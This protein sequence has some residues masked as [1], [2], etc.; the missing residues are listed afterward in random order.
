MKKLVC[1]AAL[2]LSTAS[3]FAQLYVRGNIGYNLPGGSQVIGTNYDQYYVGQ[4][5]VNESTTERVYGSFGSG[6]SFHVGV[7]ASI[8]GMLGY[9]V[10]VG[11]VVGKKY[12]EKQTYADNFG[13]D[14]YH[15][16]TWAGSIQIAPSL[17]FTAGTGNIQP[18]TRV[19]PVLGFTKMKREYSESDSYNDVEFKYEYELTG[20]VSIGFKGVLGVNFNAGKKIQFFSEISFV[21]MSTA[22][23]EIEITALTVNGEDALNS[24]PKEERKTKLKDKIDSDDQSNVDLREKYSMGSIGLQV[25]VKYVLK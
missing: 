12:S 15:T 18:Y 22:P 21:S 20:G 17:T 9:D 11:Y 8:N 4:T 1:L 2:V 7:G 6:L 14:R 19:G 23:K 5:G 13:V 3:A 25:G 16:E 24:I 10:E